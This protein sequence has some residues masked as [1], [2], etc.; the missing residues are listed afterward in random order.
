MAKYKVLLTVKDR[1]GNIKELSAGPIAVKLDA[2]DTEELSVLDKHFA[3]DDQLRDATAKSPD[4]I[5][6]AGFELEDN[7]D[8]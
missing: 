4:T 7:T 5:R 3:T 6:Y 1:Y 8:E 2:V